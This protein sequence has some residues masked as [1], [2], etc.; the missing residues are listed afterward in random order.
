MPVEDASMDV[1]TIHHVLHFLDDPA[2]AVSEAARALRPGG[3]ALIVDFAPHGI[4][5]LRSDHA[6]R[7]LGFDDA[8][9]SHWCRAA[10]FTEVTMQRFENAARVGDQPLTVCLWTALKLGPANEPEAL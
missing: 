5:A 1:V 4:D 3:R 8:E 2:I 10:G 7:R 9:V 6:H